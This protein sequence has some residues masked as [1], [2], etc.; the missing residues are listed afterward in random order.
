MTRLMLAHGQFDGSERFPKFQ[1]SAFSK[2]KKKIKHKKEGFDVF[3]LQ[4]FKNNKL[5]YTW[6]INIYYQYMFIIW[7]FRLSGSSDFKILKG[8]LFVNNK[9]A[10]QSE[11]FWTFLWLLVYPSVKNTSFCDNYSNRV[12]CYQRPS[13]GSADTWSYRFV[14]E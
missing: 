10:G 11:R 5:R 14:N 1:V 2:K 13:L 6:I 12:N 9:S 3:S 8:L 7:F 4:Q